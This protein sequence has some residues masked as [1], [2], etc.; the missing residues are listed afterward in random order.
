MSSQE[1]CETNEVL[2]YNFPHN[3][4]LQKDAFLSFQWNFS[5]QTVVVFFFWH[6]NLFKVFILSGLGLNKTCRLFN[7]ERGYRSY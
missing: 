7:P 1:L 2:L 6:C 4:G 3:H 5:P